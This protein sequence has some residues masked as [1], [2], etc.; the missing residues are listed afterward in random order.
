MTELQR[1]D[2]SNRSESVNQ[3]IQLYETGPYVSA[4]TLKMQIVRLLI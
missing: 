3:S 2:G 1:G 4:L